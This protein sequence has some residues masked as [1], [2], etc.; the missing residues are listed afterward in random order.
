MKKVE[1]RLIIFLWIFLTL[2]LFPPYLSGWGRKPPP[3]P[4][5][6]EEKIA[7]KFHI[8]QSIVLALKEK[9]Y[10]TE[11]II[12]L[13]IMA[14]AT[15]KGADEISILRE[16]GMS[17]EEVAQRCGVEMST[18]GKETQRLLSEVGGRKEEEEIKGEKE[19]EIEL[20]ID[21]EL[22]KKLEM[23]KTES[24]ELR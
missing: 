16:E 10:G 3:E 4:K 22:R 8:E 7:R 20:E 24:D 9:G 17:W 2:I 12:E 21:K 14:T 23:E 15:G 11:E 13:L 5:T 1:L 6:V 18:L 19:P